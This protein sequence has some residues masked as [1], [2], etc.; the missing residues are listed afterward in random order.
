[1]NAILIFALATIINVTLSTVRAICTIK[2]GKWLSAIMNAVCYG[3]YPLIV[4]LTAQGTVSIIINMIIT[5]L[6]NFICVWIIKFI[7]EKSRKDKLWKIEASVYE[8]YTESLYDA[9]KEKGISCNYVPTIRKYTIFN[10]YA[11]T[12]AQSTIVKELLDYHKAKY[13][14]SET[15]IL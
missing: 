1:M 7:E 14:V 5:A 13:F 15:K 12:Q 6:A 4:M 10:I 9:L 11:E 8:P 3:F 2:S